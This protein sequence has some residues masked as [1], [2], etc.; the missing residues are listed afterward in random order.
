MKSVY[1]PNDYLTLGSDSKMIQAAVD[2]AAKYG[3]EVVI[4]RVNERTGE[5][6]W[7][8]DESIKLHTGSFVTLDNCHIRLADDTF[9]HFFENDSADDF[10]EWYKSEIRQYDIR[11][12]GKG[13]AILDGGKHNGVFEKDFNIY[14]E[15]GNFV[16][17]INYKGLPSIAV[18][19]GLEFRNVERI[20]VKGLR[21]INLRYWAMCF[22]FCSFG[23]IADI[24]FE[25]FGEVPNQD[26]ID[27]RVGCNNFLVEN[28]YGL[29]GDD[30]IAL[31]N[32]AGHYIEVS[33]MDTSI[34]DIIISN[35][36]SYQSDNCDIIRILNRGG[37]VI[38]NVQIKNVVDITPEYKKDR[39]LAAIRIGDICDYPSRLNEP[40][41]TRNIIVRDVVTRAR[42]GAYIANTVVDSVFDNFMMTS[43]GGIGM[44]F[45]GCTIKNVFI[46]R[47]MYN[48]L[49]SV[50]ESDI[51]YQ[52][53]FH[54]VKIDT[55]NAFH[56]NNCEAENLNIS[57]VV[58]GKNLSYV[59]GGNS[60]I[61]IKASNVV[62]QDENTKMS[63]KAIIK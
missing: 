36:R 39:A 16:K 47:F 29:T 17:S 24:T 25:A 55:L 21:F 52:E 59:F 15:N 5:C 63:E 58:A 8:L 40:G 12:E 22:E 54:R 7:E 43:D 60:E 9:I 14:D 49:A 31:T 10:G 13:N 11:L 34:H 45:N 1:T 18:N 51:G 30:T 28:I 32:F 53:I 42:F 62:C 35:V 50:P 3:A 44:Y 26:G 2:E 33:D 37:G 27:I 46:N 19:R 6:K 20:T 4:P 23:H 48:M 56:F 61:E 41:E 57:N 38:Y